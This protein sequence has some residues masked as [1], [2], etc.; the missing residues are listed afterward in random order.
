MTFEENGDLVL[1]S[2]RRLET[3]DAV[4]GLSLD[5]RDSGGIICVYGGYDDVV[6]TD[7]FT[8]AERS[9]LAD[10]MIARWQAF[11]AAV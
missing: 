7:S 2:G 10:A 4:V 8:V 5:M 9:E 1:S 11:K 6:S 3:W